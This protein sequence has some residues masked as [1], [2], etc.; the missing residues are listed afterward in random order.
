MEERHAVPH[1]LPPVTG[2]RERGSETRPDI[3]VT[4]ETAP[5]P[6]VATAPHPRTP[7]VLVAHGPLTG[8]RRAFRAERTRP[9]PRVRGADSVHAAGHAFE[10]GV[11]RPPR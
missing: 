1:V 4:G 6:L 9:A 11:R 2:P 7:H 10:T 5:G 8:E 3:R